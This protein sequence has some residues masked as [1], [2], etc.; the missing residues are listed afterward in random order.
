[1]FVGIVG[2][3]CSGKHEV[4]EILASAYG[5]TRLY[6]RSPPSNGHISNIGN[7]DGD[8]RSSSSSS[9]EDRAGN[10]FDTVEEI[11]DHVT[12][13]WM[14][15]FV[16]CDV[17]SVHG[18]SILRKRPFFLLLSVESPMMIRYRRCVSRYQTRGLAPPT[19]EDFVE[20]SDASLYTLPT[21]ASTT[22]TATI[23]S[24]ITTT[25]AAAATAASPSAMSPSVLSIQSNESEQ[26]QEQE[27]IP[28]TRAV[29]SLQPDK[30][31]H[32]SP[33]SLSS[34]AK[35]YVHNYPPYKL[36]SMSDLSLLNTH[37]DL[38]LL[39][40]DIDQL[41]ITNPDLLRPS[42]D[43]YFMYLAN[44]AARR[45]NCMKRRVGCVLVRERRVIAT[46]YNGT[47]KNLMN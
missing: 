9:S 42:W 45:S 32:S 33:P 3:A 47:P 7:I 37:T 1:M 4:M 28:E 18:I 21:I 14:Q 6:L 43:S 17:R 40:Q 20:F 38:H 11:L 25:A 41:D 23:A 19:L 16:T 27:P 31:D 36:L 24:A 8:M 13:N 46:G 34:F 30:L 26:N 39:R 22:T 5:F 2:P 29:T 35:H 44:L 12:L 10:E 15:R